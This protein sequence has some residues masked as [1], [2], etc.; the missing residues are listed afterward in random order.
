MPVTTE[1]IAKTLYEE[2]GYVRWEE[3]PENIKAH[4]YKIV[5]IVT[6]ELRA[7][8]VFDIPAYYEVFGSKNAWRD[9]KDLQPGGFDSVT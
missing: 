2:M 1:K 3:Q 8:L 5:G 9:G 7:L 6:K 4:W